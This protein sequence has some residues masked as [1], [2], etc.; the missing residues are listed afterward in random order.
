M[1]KQVQAF[2]NKYLPNHE[3]EYCE[4]ERSIISNEQITTSGIVLKF[5]D[6][7]ELFGAA[8]SLSNN[9]PMMIAAF[10]CL[11]RFLILDQKYIQENNDTY[12]TAS[13]GIAFHETYEKACINAQLELIERSE[14]LKSW[15][16][17]QTAKII[18]SSIFCQEFYDSFKVWCFDFSNIEGVYVIGIFAM[19]NEFP[20]KFYCG[21]GSSTNLKEA[22]LK[23]KKEFLTRLS[24]LI[25]QPLD[26]IDSIPKNT[27]LYHQEFYLHSENYSHLIDWFSCIAVDQKV[28]SSLFP[29][30]KF[31]KI[32]PEHWTDFCVVKAYSNETIPLFF[33][34]PP[35]SFDFKFRYDIPHPIA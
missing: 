2:L 26:A 29:V 31:E 7:K 11:E 34:A 4:T 22:E 30:I 25:N 28:K 17:N 6:G 33:G 32:S 3:I 19:Q 14:I 24:F 13:N 9:D 16:K 23:A 8:S 18:N 27:G 1:K 10:E 21:F 5:K 20:T 12:F 35:K 15:Y